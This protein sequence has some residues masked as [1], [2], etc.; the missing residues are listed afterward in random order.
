MQVYGR[1]KAMVAKITYTYIEYI[2]A[3]LKQTAFLLSSDKNVQVPRKVGMKQVTQRKNYSSN[4]AGFI[5][6]LSFIKLRQIQLRI[7]FFI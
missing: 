5:I 3:I 6:A 1:D 2:S 7:K 4:A